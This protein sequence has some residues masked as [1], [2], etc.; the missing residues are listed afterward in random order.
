MTDQEITVSLVQ[1]LI[2]ELSETE[3]KLLTI[4]DIE[5]VVADHY[6]L[7][8]NLLRSKKRNTEIA[9]ARHVAMYLA[10]TLTNASLPQIGKNFGDRDHTSVLHACNPIVDRKEA[11]QNWS[12]SAR[13]IGG[14]GT[15]DRLK[16][17]RILPTILIVYPG[18]EFVVFC[19]IP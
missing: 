11:P 10:R 15:T 3:E 1:S 12:A 2:G 9:H 13:K 14:S 7:N 4:T 16:I 17:R 19:P 8:K 18:T 5:C 6:K